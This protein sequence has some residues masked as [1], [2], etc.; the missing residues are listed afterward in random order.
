MQITYDYLANTHL[1]HI[2]E[3]N[4]HDT[5]RNRYQI[6]INKMKRFQNYNSTILKSNKCKINSVRNRKKMRQKVDNFIQGNN[7]KKLNKEPP[8]KLKKIN[9]KKRKR[10]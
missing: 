9:R 3:T 1:K 2:M 6:I 5:L 7:S 10:K 4:K 8:D